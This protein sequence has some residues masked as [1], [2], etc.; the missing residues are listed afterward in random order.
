MKNEDISTKIKTLRLTKGYSQ[1]YLATQTQLSLRTIQRI[2]SGETEPRGDTLQRLAACL[3]VTVAQLVN[4]PVTVGEHAAA[5]ELPEDRLYLTFMH[6]SALS[7][8]IFP[9]LGVLVPYIMWTIKRNQIKDIDR[10]SKKVLN[11]QITW[12]IAI[13]L[14]YVYLFSAGGAGLLQVMGVVVLY[15]FNVVMTLVNAVLIFVNKGMFYQPALR[16]LK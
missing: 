5:S 1:D 11:F 6:L 2:E 12:C 10:V 16:L 13:V 15:A 3:D 9:L 7:F 8:M 14:Y 4:L